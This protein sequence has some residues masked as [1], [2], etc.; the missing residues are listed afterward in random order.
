MWSILSDCWYV[1]TTP[2]RYLFALYYAISLQREGEK[3]YVVLNHSMDCRMSFVDV[4][5]FPGLFFGSN[6]TFVLLVSLE[7]DAEEAQRVFKAGAKQYWESIGHFTS[8]PDFKRDF[9][10]MAFRK[11][12][13]KQY[14]QHRIRRPYLQ[15]RQ[16]RQWLDRGG[17]V[18]TVVR[19]EMT[20][21]RDH[22]GWSLLMLAIQH[23]EIP[24]VDL[25]LERGAD[26]NIVSPTGQT[27]WSVAQAGGNEYLLHRLRK[28]G[29]VEAEAT[30]P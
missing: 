27:A 20:N 19:K 17:N 4:V 30:A 24:T 23:G 6:W 1:L 28:A 13:A 8:K 18:N 25:L 14:R 10:Q 9:S 26:V 3:D 22:S 15:E 16:V 7:V 29:T 2:F 12:F 21:G 5:S 11:D